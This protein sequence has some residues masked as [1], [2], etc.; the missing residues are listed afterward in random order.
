ML[1]QKISIK[2]KCGKILIEAAASKEYKLKDLV[3]G[4]TSASLH[5]ESDFGKPTGK[6]VW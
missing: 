2:V 3:D 6:E 1:D 4:I 5:T